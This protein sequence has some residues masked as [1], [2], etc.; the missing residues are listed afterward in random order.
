MWSGKLWTVKMKL[1]PAKVVSELLIVIMP[2][3]HLI[4]KWYF[5]VDDLYTDKSHYIYY[6]SAVSAKYTF[7]KKIKNSKSKSKFFLLFIYL[8]LFPPWTTPEHMACKCQL[9][10]LDLN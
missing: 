2:L 1:L 5:I 7:L 10:T 9:C 8:C 4:F 6:F 3:I